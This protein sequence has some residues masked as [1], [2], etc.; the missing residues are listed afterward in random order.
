MMKF[1]HSDETKGHDPER[2]YRHGTLIDHPEQ[3]TRVDL[4]KNALDEEGFPRGVVQ[5]FGRA[6]LEAAHAPDYLEFL[7]T[8]WERRGEMGVERDEF[9]STQFPRTQMHHRPESLRGLLGYYTADTSTPIR[10]GTWNA[11]YSASQ[12]ALSAAADVANG[13]PNAYALCRPP[14]H[15]CFR[16]C[17]GG[18][19]YLN[20]TA[21][22]ACFLRE[23]MGSRIAILDVDV[24][25]GNGTQGIFYSD[26]S[27]LTI[28]LHADPADY[29]P[30]YAGYTEETGEGAG[31]GFNLN[32]PLPHHSGDE[33]FFRALD[34]SLERI[35]QFAPSAL[36]VALGLDASEDDPLGVL[37]I[38]TPGFAEIGR[39]IG[40]ED[41]PTLLVQEGG[42]LSPELP[43][44]LISF[45]R[46]FEDGA[47][48]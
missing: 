37:N 38:T 40:A 18:F 7:S 13:A 36:V 4:M 26:P 44:N 32:I 12:V 17:A 20:N 28:S 34:C 21:I 2:F 27:V 30:Y 19:C 24:H 9:L 6:P 43:R 35:R 14:G 48:A 16:D 41:Y 23:K 46:G 25:H 5:D 45:L 15:H 31:K 8:F 3:P 47:G 22:A 39:R 42:Y 33:D 10:A 1:F 29:F 11:V